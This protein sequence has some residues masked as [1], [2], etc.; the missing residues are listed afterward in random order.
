MIYW[1]QKYCGSDCTGPYDVIF[2]EGMTVRQFIDEMLT[3]HKSEWGYIGIDKPGSIFGKPCIEYSH[4]ELKGQSMPEEYMDKVITKVKGSG[5]WSRS[6]F[7]LVL[8]EE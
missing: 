6:D 5:G 2:T 8:E 1:T 7:Q 3:E 4:G